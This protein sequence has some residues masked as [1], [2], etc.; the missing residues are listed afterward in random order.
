MIL[1]CELFIE[2]KVANVLFTDKLMTKEKETVEIIML[3]ST[4]DSFSV[5]YYKFN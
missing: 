4:E 3:Y 1:N 2:E 5:P